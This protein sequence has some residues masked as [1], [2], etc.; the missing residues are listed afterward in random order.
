MKRRITQAA[1]VL[2]LLFFMLGMVVTG[3]IGNTTLPGYEDTVK[4]QRMDEMTGAAFLTYLTDFRERVKERHPEGYVQLLFLVTDS[5]VMSV[6]LDTDIGIHAFYFVD[7]DRIYELSTDCFPQRR[8]GFVLQEYR[9][10]LDLPAEIII[11]TDLYCER[12]DWFK[13]DSMIFRYYYGTQ[14]SLSDFAHLEWDPDA[15]RLLDFGKDR[16]GFFV[17][18]LEDGCRGVYRLTRYTEAVFRQENPEVAAAWEYGDDDALAAAFRK[19]YPGMTGFIAYRYNGRWESEQKFYAVEDNTSVRPVWDTEQEEDSGMLAVSRTYGYFRRYPYVYEVSEVY[20]CADGAPRQEAAETDDYIKYP[21]IRV[22][23]KNGIVSN[24]GRNGGYF[25][26]VLYSWG[27]E[28]EQEL[29]ADVA[30]LGDGVDVSRLPYDGADASFWQ[31]LYELAGEKDR[32]WREDTHIGIWYGV[33]G[34]TAVLLDTASEEHYLFVIDTDQRVYK[35]HA[36]EQSVMFEGYWRNFVHNYLGRAGFLSEAEMADKY[37]GTAFNRGVIELH[38]K[39]FVWQW[40]EYFWDIQEFRKRADGF[41]FTIVGVDNE[42]V[43]YRLQKYARS[44]FED[45]DSAL[46]ERMWAGDKGGMLLLMTERYRKL[47]GFY[48]YPAM[49]DG[50]AEAVFY[51]TYTGADMRGYLCYGDAVYEIAELHARAAGESFDEA[52]D[53]EQGASRFAEGARRYGGFDSRPDYLWTEDADYNFRWEDREKGDYWYAQ[54]IGAGRKF[55]ICMTR[56]EAEEETDP[57]EIGEPHDITVMALREEDGVENPETV[58]Q[59]TVYLSERD[60]PLQFTDFNMDGWLDIRLRDYY[61]ANGGRCFHYCYSPSRGMFVRAAEELDDYSWYEPDPARRQVTVYHYGAADSGTQQLYQWENETDCRLLRQIDYGSVRDPVADDAFRYF[62]TVTEFA[63][64]R[65]RVLFHESWPY[66]PRD[67]VCQ[68]E[69]RERLAWDI[70][71]N[72]EPAG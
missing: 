23:N 33:E 16:D 34:R 9:R 31:Y 40:D 25:Y 2:G 45:R 64:G 51:E 41:T 24:V 68:P 71:R 30:A 52:E 22:Y 54:D 11:P 46:A 57:E 19:K 61:G 60:N 39:S 21:L 37:W 3:K 36:E 20:T 32:S 70:F 26:D 13:E 47:N 6:R 67:G 17:S 62:W 35:L 48:C 44:A 72:G 43:R 69:D 59:F 49:R 63:G 14:S 56:Q 55:M 8:W 15:A 18:F 58:Q 53:G 27:K 29:A 1:A 28:G 5:G 65:R 66:A 7:G 10:H 42:I 50:E 38:C 12:D 4:L